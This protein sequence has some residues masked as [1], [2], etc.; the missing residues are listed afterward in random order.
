MRRAD[1]KISG[2][3]I[4]ASRLFAKNRKPSLLLLVKN[5]ENLFDAAKPQPSFRWVERNH[6]LKTAS[7]LSREGWNV[8]FCGYEPYLGTGLENPLELLRGV[9]E[10]RLSELTA[11]GL[12]AR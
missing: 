12:A 2:N 11:T 9:M 6:F 4:D 10:K 1:L 7:D 5:S 8:F 3:V